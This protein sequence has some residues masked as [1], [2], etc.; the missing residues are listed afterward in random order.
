LN[1]DILDGAKLK[2]MFMAAAQFLETNKE[3]VNALNVFPVPD[4]DTGTNMSLTM[5]SAAREIKAADSDDLTQVVDALSRGALKGA[6]GNSGV[7]LSQLFRGFARALKGEE[8]VTTA[9]YADALK[10]GV[11]TAYKAVMKPVEGTILTVARV[12]AEEAK[13]I[14]AKISDFEIFYDRIIDVAKDTLNKTPEML[15]VLKQAGVVDSG[16]MGLLYIM[17]GQSHALE[18]DFDPEA[19]MEQLDAFIGGTKSASTPATGY[20]GPAGVPEGSIEYGYCTEFFI[21]NL[22]PY[23]REEDIDKLKEKLER[24]GDS[25]VV[26]GDE[27][28]IKVHFHTNMPGKGLQLGLRFGELSS[29]KIDNMREQHHHVISMEA[30]AAPKEPE[31]NIGLVSVSMGDGIASVFKDLNA[32]HIIEGGQTMNP[33]IEDILN[34]VDKVNAKEVFVLPNNSNIVLSANQA[35]DIS[36]KK[37]HVIPTKTIPQGMAALIAYNPEVD[38]ETNIASMIRA[39]KQVKTGQVTYAVRDSNFDNID[40]KQGDI[41]GIT[42]SK[43]SVTGSD[44]ADVTQ[45]LLDKMLQDGGEIVT[46]LYGKD[47]KEEDT[48][49]I[50]SHLESQYPDVDV[51]ILSGGQPLYY[52]ILS[53][54]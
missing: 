22:H 45:Q 43:I 18:D 4:G 15:P 1:Q 36:E 30:S 50:R 11:E 54:E 21:K 28:L 48:E 9:K 47:A 44:I 2:L 42:E 39:M 35:A 7:I 29:I 19:P 5:L 24:L 25:I 51:E 38:A 14:S 40:I 12:T 3:A 31:K 46:V 23:I 53:V 26:V 41:M 10:A 16:G 52:Y 37:I 27:E 8:Q 49:Q 13:K 33:S 20:A 17:M 34:A 32:D 6:R